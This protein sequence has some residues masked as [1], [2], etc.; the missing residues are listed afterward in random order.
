MPG[1]LIR[2]LTLNDV[3]ELH[4]LRLRNRKF[5]EPYE[6]TQTDADFSRGATKANIDQSFREE[7]ED[8]G[9]AFAICRQEDGV[10]VGRIRISAVFRGPWNSCNLGYYV[11]EE[12][13]GNGYATD[14][15]REV[16]SYAFKKL[17]LHRVQAAVL[18]DNP[19][20]K[21]VLEKN[22]FRKEGLALRYLQIAGVYRDHEIFAL[23]TEDIQD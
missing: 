1:A 18:T 7:R 3:D 9:T 11:G 15:V 6:P 2:K 20:S 5:F 12:F 10:L 22:G 16:V 17:K 23:T 19:R 13:M 21:R 14:A 4:A 8:R